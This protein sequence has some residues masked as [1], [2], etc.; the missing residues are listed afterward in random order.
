ML[1]Q[2]KQADL[3]YSHAYFLLSIILLI[4]YLVWKDNVYNQIVVSQGSQFLV[5]SDGSKIKQWFKNREK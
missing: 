5:L 3:D 2:A 4:D 1:V